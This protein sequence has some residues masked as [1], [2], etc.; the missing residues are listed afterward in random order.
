MKKRFL[1]FLMFLSFIC[2]SYNVFALEI[3]DIYS[4]E[5]LLVNL[6]TDEILFAKNTND[7]A[8]PIA[9]LT[10]LMTYALAVEH[11]DD[12]ENTM[13]VVPE[14][15]VSDMIS[16]GASRA[17]LVEGYEYSA[18]DL[19]YGLM[20]P[21]GCDAAETLAYYISDGDIP[22]FVEMMNAKAT[23]LG[24]TNTLYIDSHGIGT[25]TEDNM[26]TEQDQYKLIKYVFNLPY[27]KEI[28]ST[29]YYDI[30]GNKEDEVID[31]KVRNTN[32][33]IGEYSGG[34]YYYPY[35]IGGKSGTLS[36]AGKCLVTLAKKGN[37]HIVAITLGVPWKY[38][39][40]YTYH[41]T[42]NL[43]LLKYA[44]DN[45]T[46]NV[47]VDVGYE[48]RSMEIGKQLKIDYIVSDETKI[49]WS[50]SN[51]EVASV[52]ENGVV[53][54]HKLGQVRITATTETGNV[55][56]T[57]VSVGFYNGVHTKYST[58]PANN[59]GGW[60]PIDWDVII[61]KGF[62]YVVIR[63]GYG[64]DTQDRTFVPNMT[65]ALEKGL[66]VGIW[67]EGYAVTIEEAE[68]EASNL[69]RILETN[70]PNM[71]DE[72]DLPIFYNLY[73]ADTS[74]PVVLVEVAKKFN[75]VMAE[76]GY[77][78]VLELGKTKL[79]TM[80]LVD[81]KNNNIDL[82]I[83]YRSTP[84]DF[85]VIMDANGTNADIWNYKVNAYL[86]KEGIGTN[87]SLSLT[88]MDYLKMSTT[89]PEYVAPL[90]EEPVIPEEPK[91]EVVEEEKTVIVPVVNESVVTK[92]E[93]KHTIVDSTE[94]VTTKDYVVEFNDVSGLKSVLINKVLLEGNY[95]VDNN[96]II[97]D[98]EYIKQLDEGKHVVSFIFE[99]ETVTDEFN[100]EKE[101]EN[102]V[103]D[104]DVESD[105]EEDKKSNNAVLYIIISLVLAV[106]IV[107][108]I[109]VKKHE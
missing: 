76:H 82:S 98:F 49:T 106:G 58:G 100:Y 69:I 4:N 85:E 37:D 73:F 44:F 13:I 83:I 10:K 80:D 70:F 90:P 46:K 33:L 11:I 6:D 22:K 60:D 24:M 47:T 23:E 67:Y 107:G 95:T 56:Y 5:A 64:T 36:V 104:E 14:G 92:E 79:S 109:V 19:L 42:D 101:K 21:S 9:S 50:S 48:F 99:N 34:E 3:S 31:N 12:L 54:S 96:K 7:E 38:N 68:L 105:K 53:T 15:V 16:M 18:L 59:S 71:K 97:I 66:N 87:A 8:V 29:E 93:V 74:D 75:S 40:S 103:I 91:D 78:V 39:S 35:S 52:D 72:L 57:Y 2:F 94:K 81:L 30:T 25:A 89:H 102:V 86:G 1:M 28:V 84:P 55:D 65:S 26:S 27:F 63:A 41:L 88:Y 77:K 17:D 45:H 51:P 108:F 62:D 61:N 20:L 32:Y 43:T